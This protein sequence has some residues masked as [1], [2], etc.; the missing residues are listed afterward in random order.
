MKISKAAA[1]ALACA[2]ALSC[3][4]AYPAAYAEQEQLALIETTEFLDAEPDDTDE[5]SVQEIITYTFTEKISSYSASPDGVVSLSLS[6]DG[7]D[8]SITGLKAGVADISAVTASG[9]EFLIRITVKGSQSSESDK[10]VSYPFDDLSL[11]AGDVFTANL[12]GTPGD[13]LTVYFTIKTAQGGSSTTIYRGRSFDSSG[14]ASFSYT[15]PKAAVSICVDI[16]YTLTKPSAEFQVLRNGASA[17]TTTTAS[18]SGGTSTTTTT[19]TASSVQQGTVITTTQTTP[20]SLPDGNNSAS[21]FVCTYRPV[22][23]TYNAVPTYSLFTDTDYL[24]EV[25]DSKGNIYAV[26][27][28][29]DTVA[30][31][32]NGKNDDPVW[33][34]YSGFN[35]GAATIGDNDQMYILWGKNLQSTSTDENNVVLARYD[36]DGT[37]TGEF[38]LSSSITEA[39]IPF[40][41]GN[42][43]IAYNGG[44][45]AVLMDTEWKSG[46]QGGG[47]F[48]FDTAKEQFDFAK[49]NT[50]SHSFGVSLI[51]FKNGFI[52]IQRGD[53]YD[54]AIVFHELENTKKVLVKRMAYTISSIYNEPGQHQNATFTYMGGTAATSETFAV[55][56]KSERFYT[57]NNYAD[58]S[59]DTYD[60]FVRL[61]PHNITDTLPL[62]GE[63]RK[64][65]L[66]GKI[67][68]TNVVWLTNSDKTHQAGNVKIVSLSGDRYCVLWEELTEK[69]FSDVCYVILDKYGNRLTGKITVD[70]ARLSSTSIQPIVQ[71]DVLTWAVADAKNNNVTWYTLDTS[72]AVSAEEV[73]GDVNCDGEFSI[74]DA[75]LL[76]RYI[77]KGATL[78]E[79]GAEAAD[80]N[81]DG[82][83]DIFDSILMNGAVVSVLSES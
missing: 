45:I 5:I 18:G 21:T 43:N 27:G 44:K 4:T 67:V 30:M 14:T 35:F 70:N 6:D 73:K 50:C 15:V 36:L 83:I 77:L 8:L 58:Y 81:S 57:S 17:S 34:R 12:R 7:K 48:R 51:P 26:L 47:Y 82:A 56:G 78:T 3:V 29:K 25:S 11:D 59:T 42:A 69:K 46:H 16:D 52:S 61:M 71:N 23:S 75:V 41:A 72:K 31:L 39:T 40:D 80:F 13:S 32:K 74:A 24:Q 79:K 55:A 54:R 68:D 33:F 10:T 62:A 37:L 38:P 2:S 60:V 65:V 9:Y 76:R 1:S 64:D 22:R 63:Y 28:E 20:V 49:S 53:C 66:T 19:T